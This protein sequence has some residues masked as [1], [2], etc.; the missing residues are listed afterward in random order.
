MHLSAIVDFWSPLTS[1]GDDGKWMH[2]DDKGLLAAQPHSFNLDHPVSPY[3]GD[4]L[5]APVIILGLNAGYDEKTT[6]AEFGDEATVREYVSQ[7]ADPGSSPWRLIS[8]YY[9]SSN[10]WP[11]MAT[12][13]AAWI[14]ASPYRSP[15][16]SSETANKKLAPH[17]PS[18][19]F[20]NH[21]MK[22]AVMPLARSGERLVVIK[23]KSLWS[24]FQRP[25]M[26]ALAPVSRSSAST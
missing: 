24:F 19:R 22:E 16:L 20:H 13:E 12:R 15:N 10:S 3:V 17:L 23:R 21:W 1:P 25:E 4:I 11:F 6:N 8:S 7:V 26:S 9:R 5:H 2:P 14:N 18:T